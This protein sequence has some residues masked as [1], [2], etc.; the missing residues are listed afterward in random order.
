TI[1]KNVDY[2]GSKAHRVRWLKSNQDCYIDPET[3]LPIAMGAYEISYEEPPEATFDIPT[4]P[5]GVMLV[6]KRPG[7]PEKPEPEWMRSGEVAQQKFD[8]ARK[9]SAQGEYEKAVELFRRVVEIQ[10]LRNWAWFWMGRAHYELRE[11]NAAVYE[12]SKVIDMFGKFQTVPHYCHLAR[13]FAYASKGMEEMARQ[14]FQVAV[15]VMIDAL[16]HI[17]AG[18]LFDFADDPLRCGGGLLEGCRESPGKEQSLAMMINRLRITTGQDFG[19]DAKAPA[20]QN[21]QAI[22]GWEQWF[23]DSGETKFTPD[24][25]LVAMP[26]IQE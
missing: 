12:F 2:W 17:E 7:A 22:A 3:K 25:E 5:G 20:E 23:K 11:H 21:E 14:D 6:D 26:D 24:A 4:I 13:G 10:P 9:A 1:E 18:R 19:Y 16:R 8:E 15:P